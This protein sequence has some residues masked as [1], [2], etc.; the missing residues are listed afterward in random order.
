MRTERSIIKIFASKLRSA[1]DLQRFALAVMAVLSCSIVAGPVVAEEDRVA[2]LERKVDVLTREI[3]QIRL[4]GASD[5]VTY[6]SRFGFAPAASKVY[7]V[8]QGVSIGG[9]GEM[10]F[11]NFDRFREDDVPANKID[12]LDYLRQIIYLGYKF[13]DELLFNSEIEFEHAGIG[14]AATGA[15]AVEFAYLDWSRD[16]RFG[17]R[18]GMLLQ[19]LGLVNELH[20]SPIYIGARRPDVEQRIIPTTW[21]TNGAGVYG[22]IPAGLSYRAYFTEGLNAR[23]FS[24]SGGI[25]D[26]R[27]SGSFSRVVKPAFS[28]RLDYHGLPALLVGVSGYTGDSWQESQPIDTMITPRVTLFDVHARIMWRGLE[29]R[30][31]WAA[32]TLDDAADLSDKLGFTG[33][34]RLGERFW[35]WYVESEYDVLPLFHPGTHYGLLPYV[36]YERYDTQDDVP[37]GTENPA[38][39][40]TVLT[41]GAGFK[42]HPNAVL[43][44]DRQLRQNE[45]ETET[46]QWNVQLGYLF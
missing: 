30:G 37:G 25:R 3:E 1:R 46:S 2:E 39:E 45:A 42:P 24:A 17:V 23:R 7:H 21:R 8:G 34:N 9:Y 4:G 36:R 16:P 40:R 35:G 19:P 44:V 29:A 11:E 10:L 41:L 31:V 13:N 20:E 22:E 38:N 18:A 32:G 27:Q 43:K 33:G 14:G 6:A 5:S 12:Q 15:V 28:G 26:G